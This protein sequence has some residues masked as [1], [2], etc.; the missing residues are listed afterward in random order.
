VRFVFIFVFKQRNNCNKFFCLKLYFGWR[1][2]QICVLFQCSSVLTD[3]TTLICFTLKS[4]VRSSSHLLSRSQTSVRPTAE[5]SLR[6]AMPRVTLASDGETSHLATYAISQRSVFINLTSRYVC[7]FPVANT[8][9]E[10][11]LFPVSE[12]LIGICWMARVNKWTT[13][14]HPQHTRTL[15]VCSCTHVCHKSEH[16]KLYIHCHIHIRFIHRRSQSI[17]EY[18]RHESDRVKDIWQGMSWSREKLILQSV[19]WKDEQGE[20]VVRYCRLCG[21][22]SEVYLCVCVYVCVCARMCVCAYV[23]MYA[24]ICV[25]VCLCM[26]VCAYV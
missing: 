13:P 6:V 16:F 19:L 24:Y 22:S 18:S 5:T 8:N 4:A 3:W 17:G 15:D 10:T 11:N 9:I 7:L 1:N 21:G 2:T 20:W 14:A 12:K 26:C 25:C 23:C